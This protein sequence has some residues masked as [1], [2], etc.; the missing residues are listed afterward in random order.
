MGTRVTGPDLPFWGSLS[1]PRGHPSADLH[2]SHSTDPG[3]AYMWKVPNTPLRLTVSQLLFTLVLSAQMILCPLPHFWSIAHHHKNIQ[4]SQIFL[5]TWNIVSLY[6]VFSVLSFPLSSWNFLFCL[7]DLLK[8]PE[9]FIS[10]LKVF[11]Y[12]SSKEKL[13][14][15]ACIN[16]RIFFYPYF[17]YYWA[18]KLVFWHQ[19]TP[20]F[21]EVI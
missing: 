5:H 3:G 15:V 11:P 16:N 10:F 19:I 13:F 2:A 1:S 20:F 14:K 18:G 7:Q 4:D 9:L 12:P 21:H 6:T 8:S 17:G